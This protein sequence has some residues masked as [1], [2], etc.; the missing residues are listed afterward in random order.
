M[1]TQIFKLLL[2]SNAIFGDI[3][4]SDDAD[5]STDADDADG[6]DN[7]DGDFNRIEQVLY[8]LQQK[9]AIP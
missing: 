6:D 5:E 8:K 4:E 3:D 1:V 7:A 2:H 9:T